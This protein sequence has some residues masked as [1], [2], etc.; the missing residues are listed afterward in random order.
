MPFADIYDLSIRI[1]PDGFSFAVSEGGRALAR[2]QRKGLER[3]DVIPLLERDMKQLQIDYFQEPINL[4][5]GYFYN[6]VVENIDTMSC[7]SLFPI[8]MFLLFYV[9]VV[10]CRHQNR[11]SPKK[12]GR[13]KSGVGD[14]TLFH[15]RK[16]GWA[17]M[18]AH[19]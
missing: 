16:C 3:R 7:R 9:V 1:F 14:T 5:V 13:W 10:F 6:F 8:M 19:L 17:V 2:S 11:S 18:S 12:S 4:E 15:A